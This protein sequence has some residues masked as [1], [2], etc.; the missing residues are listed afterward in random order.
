MVALIKQVRDVS[1]MTSERERVNAVASDSL[2]QDNVMLSCPSPLSLSF[3][4]GCSP[5]SVMKLVEA[6]V[7]N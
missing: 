2:G 1:D 6:V 4:P 3:S 5:A 7:G